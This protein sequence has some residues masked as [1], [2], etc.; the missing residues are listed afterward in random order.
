[1]ACPYLAEVRMVFCRAYPV[2]LLA[3]DRLSA[4]SLCCGDCYEGCAAYRELESGAHAASGDLQ[5]ELHAVTA[6]GG[7]P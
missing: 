3:S 4:V 1:M 5:P 6:T 2:K 7:K